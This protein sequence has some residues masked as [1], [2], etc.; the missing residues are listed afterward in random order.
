MKKIVIKIGS[1]TLTDGNN[2]IDRDFLQTIAD[3]VSAVRDQGWQP[4]IVT[5]AAI[6]CGLEAMGLE[7]RPTDIPSLQA[8]ASVGQSVLASSYAQAFAAHD[9]T[10]SLV[11][12][13]RRDTADRIAYLHARDTF[14][15][16]LEYGVIPIVNENDTV[17]VE[18]IRF[19][20]NDT[21]AA[22][23]GCLVQADMVVILSDIDGL[24]DANP[25]TD[26]DAHLIPVVEHID[27]SVME[28]AGDAGSSIGSGGMI[29]KIKAAR[30]LMA[31]GIEMVICQGRAP[32]IIEDAAAGRGVGTRFIA[33]KTP[34]D[35]TAR[36]LWIALGDSAKG[37]VVVDDGARRALIRQGSSLLCVGVSRVEGSFEA[38]DI[39]DVCDLSGHVI[40][41][42]KVSASSDELQ[43]GCG[44]TSAELESN[45]LLA[46][47]A[48]RPVMHRDEL[49]VFE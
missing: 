21:L 8:A 44:R 39:V 45:R 19:G 14:E 5:S 9:V 47:L 35:I 36:K 2:R 25:N 15:R 22:L 38:G 17:S 4:I 27:R 26:H 37:S 16:L 43:L 20:D 7:T 34:H 30:V 13:T 11:L 33:A 32:H 28:V 1:S 49:I 31:A 24:Y 46:P 10:T 6:A 29:T 12:L 23:V 42:G 3:Q 41:R 18:Q 40:A 48:E